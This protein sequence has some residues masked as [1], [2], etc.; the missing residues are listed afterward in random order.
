[1]RGCTGTVILDGITKVACVSIV[2][3]TAVWVSVGFA[4][5]SNLPTYLD[6]AEAGQDF[7][8]QGEYSG[9]F[10]QDDGSETKFGLQVIALGEGKFHC[11]AYD[12]GLP[13]DGWDQVTKI[14]C[15]G[16]LKDG[17]VVFTAEEGSGTLK[18][19][20]IT[21]RN[22]EGTELGKLA[23]LDRKSPTL[24]QA[25]PE[26]AVV[27]F[28]GSTVDNFTG[29]KLTDDKLLAVPGP[30]PQSK[31]K[32]QD[33]TLHIEFRTPF[34]PT[35]RGQARGNC[36]VFLQGRYEIQ[37]LDSFGL[38]GLINECGALYSLAAPRENAC[39]P[40]LSWQ[41]YDVDFTAARFD[42][43]GK[44]VKNAT[45]TVRHNGIL[46]HE[47]VE[48]QNPSP[49]GIEESREPGP[50]LLHYH[51]NPVMFRNIWVVERKSEP[52]A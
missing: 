16:E 37:V 15:D 5:D 10:A 42:E 3:L 52:A 33:F 48:L 40:P 11:V 23:R 7:A 1:M 19:G 17:Q 8:I 26:G 29:A 34:M 38:E 4:A 20:V 9:S 22:A 6:P 31:A 43:T 41:T 21:I 12:G 50:I 28:D 25:P 32:F 44:K 2:W 47:N 13:G 30:H 46:V 24:G 49:G 39:F 18:D 27:L 35:A 36:G 45:A 14:E 51:G